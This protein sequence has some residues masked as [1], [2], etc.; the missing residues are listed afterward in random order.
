MFVRVATLSLTATLFTLLVGCPANAEKTPPAK[1]ASKVAKAPA[2]AATKAVLW[3]IE[4]KNVGPSWVLATVATPAGHEA[5]FKPEVEP[6]L[7]SAKYIGTEFYSDM[8]SSVELAQLILTKEATLAKILGE[9]RFKQVVPMLEARG[10]PRAVADKLQPWAVVMLLMT[11]KAGKEIPPMDEYLYQYSAEMQKPYFAIES[12]GE[13]LK[14]YQSL[15]AD[16]QIVLIDTLIKKAPELDQANSRNMTAYIGYEVEQIQPLAQLEAALPSTEQAWFKAWHHE[17]KAK[18]SQ[19]MLERLKPAL[20]KGD[21]FFTMHASQLTGE[22][23]LLKTLQKAGYTV[24]P[25]P[26]VAA[27]K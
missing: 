24:S 19:S 10:Y 15:A 1:T 8:N 22:D 14:P 4:S 18:R 2:A 13:Q 21:I 3:K 17:V 16:K 7:L 20:A 25:V 5:E 12:V 11:P 27:S 23:G 9:E 26:A 6:A